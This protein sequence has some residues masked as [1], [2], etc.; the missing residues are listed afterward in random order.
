MNEKIKLIITRKTAEYKIYPWKLILHIFILSMMTF[1]SVILKGYPFCVLYL[2][3]Y[4]L[5][6]I[7]LFRYSKKNHCDIENFLPRSKEEI[8]KT[9][10]IENVIVS[11]IY[12]IALGIGYVLTIHYSRYS[13]DVWKEIMIGCICEMGFLYIMMNDLVNQLTKYRLIKNTTSQNMV[14]D[15]LYSI[16]GKFCTSLIPFFIAYVFMWLWL[17]IELS[18]LNE[19]GLIDKLLKI[20][21]LKEVMILV[22]LFYIL[23]G[24]LAMK[25]VRRMYQILGEVLDEY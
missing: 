9:I 5:M 11:V 13:M 22:V 8:L 19:I 7:G 20:L 1:L 14:S 18:D 4:S 10:G 6:F 15:N 17:S 21:H 24:I 25:A 12:T 16:G 3:M 23:S 2:G